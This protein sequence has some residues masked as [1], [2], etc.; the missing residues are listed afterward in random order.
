MALFFSVYAAWLFNQQFC[1]RSRDL[2]NNESARR[3]AA[4]D[5]LMSGGASAA[6]HG[7][8]WKRALPSASIDA[9]S[10]AHTCEPGKKDAANSQDLGIVFFVALLTVST[11]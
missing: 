10:K 3:G 8:G 2:I 9:L 11:G 7:A 1:E 6:F 5:L 4:A